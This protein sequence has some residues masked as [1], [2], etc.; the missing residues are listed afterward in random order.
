MTVEGLEVVWVKGYTNILERRAWFEDL[1]ADRVELTHLCGYLY[2]FLG[3]F[4]QDPAF[5]FIAVL[6]MDNTSLGFRKRK[7]N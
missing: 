3:V 1:L 5:L 6:P 2:R 7:K 4:W